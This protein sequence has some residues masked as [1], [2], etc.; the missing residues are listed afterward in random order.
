[1]KKFA[2]G[3]QFN[4]PLHEAIYRINVGQDITEE[5]AYNAFTYTLNIEDEINRGVCLGVLLNGIV[6]KRP[7]IHEILGILK[8]TLDYDGIDITNQKRLEMPN[9]ARVIGY[10]GSGKK[11]IK[12][13]NVSS[14]AAI[15]AATAG[16]YVAKSCSGSTSS[17]S[18]SA[19][20][21]EILGANISQT[22]EEMIDIMKKT[23]LGFFKIEKMIPKFD[24]V[25]GGHFYAPNALSF[26]LAG[27]LL[28]FRPDNLFYGL[29]HPN[30]HLLINVLKELNY[31][32]AFVASTTDDGVHFLDEI[33]IFGM[34]SV[35]GI[36]EHK[37]GH[38]LTFSPAEDLKLQG[39]NRSSIEPGK[40][41]LENVKM[42]VDVL[43][44]KGQIA[45][46]D[47]ICVNAGT[48]LCLDKKAKDLTEGYT[49]SKEIIKSGKAIEKLIEFIIATG[50]NLNTLNQF[51][52]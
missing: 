8:A 15:V 17:V 42:G 39:Y 21:I 35:I 22:N 38:T 27:I 44:G 13:I 10:A 12:T 30:I 37:I 48:L 5:M 36:Q 33:G 18:G 25:Y 28:P 49:I 23:G 45:H 40:T 16:T 20:F 43:R 1:M 41:R 3:I 29:A 31:R 9:N 51:L 34:T 14:C 26:G 47:L 46:E 7:Q 11:G 50:G 32:Y 6:S 19:D 24:K 52:D 4:N 2:N